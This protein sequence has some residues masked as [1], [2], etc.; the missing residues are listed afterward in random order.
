LVV[1][2]QWSASTDEALRAA[3]LRGLVLA[4]AR[5]GNYET[6][7]ARADSLFLV[8][9]VSKD[10]AFAG[11]ARVFLHAE[12]GDVEQAWSALNEAALLP[13][14]GETEDWDLAQQ[15]LV[16]R[17]GDPP[18]RLQPR[19]APAIAAS[20]TNE[21][22]SVMGLVQINSVF[23]N[24][25]QQTGTVVYAVKY[26]GRVTVS[27]YDV[28]GRRVLGLRNQETEPGI[29]RLT[30]HD[31]RLAAGVYYLRLVADVPGLGQSTV[32]YPVSIIR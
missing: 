30:I 20:G 14:V 19:L 29:H 17:F 3:A 13:G 18:A 6:A 10:G 23:P 4:H 8:T 32:T 21:I 11:L 27:L 2:D 16:A 24:P 28:L 5:S 22:Q 26:G 1:L 12:I 25:I 9:T 15:D 31:T 7:I